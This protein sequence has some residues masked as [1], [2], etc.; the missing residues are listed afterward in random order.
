MR[1]LDFSDGFESSTPPSNLAIEATGTSSNP[2]LVS[3]GTSISVQAVTAEDQYVAGTGGVTMTADPQISAGTYEGQ[4]ITLIGTSDTDYVTIVDGAGLWLT[5]LCK[6]TN[7]ALI[8][9]RWDVAAQL[10]IERFRNG[11]A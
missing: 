3:A 8:S 2:T 1:E 10:W 6:L 9:L 5:G 7:G 4:I 11:F